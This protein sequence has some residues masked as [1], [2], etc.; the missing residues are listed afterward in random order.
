MPASLFLSGP[1]KI[2]GQNTSGKH[3]GV[4]SCRACAAFFR[5][6]A[7]WSPKKAHC[8]RGNCASFE[9]KNLNC[10]QCRLKKCID[11][12]MDISKFQ[13]NRDSISS[14]C[15]KPAIITRP[16]SLAT[17]LG[18]PEFMLCCEPDKASPVKLT[19]D[20]T[21]LIDIARNMLQKKPTFP[22]M[23]SCSNSLEILSSSLDKMRSLKANEGI[24]F[25]KKLGR[26][27]S[28]YTWEQGFLRV[29]E[30]FSYFPEF[31]ELDESVK[32]E[33]V[34]TS[35]VAWTRLDKIFETAANQKN[36]VFGDSILMVGNECCMDMND[37]EVDLSWCTNYSLEQ[38]AYFFLTPEDIKNYCE[39]LQYIKDLDPSG[40]EVSYMLLQLS[41]Y[42]AGSKGQGKVMEV[43]EMLLEAQA[44]NLHKYYVEKLKMPNYSSRL[45][46]LMK[47]N[48]LLEADLRL[49]IDK[50]RIADVFDILKVDFSHPEMYDTT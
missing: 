3:F 5:R 24:K 44:D 45:S 38:L 43:A 8:P 28:L 49:R 2:C 41:L 48:R 32:L 34:K 21:Y 6:A 19:I 4:L 29:V 23:P 25:I 15:K 13:T 36:G 22:N 16:Q 33:I 39:V 46:Q 11:V 27:E 9:N 26:D 14:A 47:I 20:V 7:L 12:G 40:I 42:H 31:R 10:K 30:W 37:Y 1:C 17:F 35:W 18:R 50:K